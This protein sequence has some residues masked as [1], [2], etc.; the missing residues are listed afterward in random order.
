MCVWGVGGEEGNP[1]VVSALENGE[2][3]EEREED[4]DLCV[5]KARENHRKTTVPF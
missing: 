5:G 3:G 1:A 2:K 4:T